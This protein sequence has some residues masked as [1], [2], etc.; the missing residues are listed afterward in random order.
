MKRLHLD[1]RG[2]RRNPPWVGR[3][4][5]MAALVV[6]ADMASSYQTLH[7]AM[8][9]NELR[10]AK[11]APAR[12]AAKLSA[13]EV[14]AVRETVQRLTL[15]WDELFLALESAASDSVALA[16]IE[17]DTAKGIVT[18]SG[19]GKDYLAALSYVSNLRRSDRLARVELVR[20]ESKAAD[21]NGPVSF[22]VT[23]AWSAR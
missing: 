10:L 1:F 18:I 11:W 20:H 3:V 8:Q 9:A 2:T 17:P 21:P 4:L 13:A 23:A 12:P 15:P 6:C 5:L 19:D 16:A 7:A 22:A 14:E